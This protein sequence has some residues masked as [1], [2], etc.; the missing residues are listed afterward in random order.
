M[1]YDALEHIDLQLEE[2]SVKESPTISIDNYFSKDDWGHVDMK[3]VEKFKFMARRLIQLFLG[4]EATILEVEN[5][6]SIKHGTKTNG[7][8]F[9][10]DCKG[11]VDFSFKSTYEFTKYAMNNWFKINILD[12]ELCS[13]HLNP[14]LWEV[15][16]SGMTRIATFIYNV[17]GQTKSYQFIYNYIQKHYIT[18]TYKNKSGLS[19]KAMEMV[20]FQSITQCK[21]KKIKGESITY[22][23]H[24][25]GQRSTSR[26]DP[27]KLVC[28]AL[29]VAPKRKELIFRDERLKDIEE[30][31]SNTLTK[32]D[33]LKVFEYTKYNGFRLEDSKEPI[34]YMG[35][36][37]NPEIDYGAYIVFIDLGS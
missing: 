8:I 25:N 35:F 17:S 32:E 37:Y 26:F 31:A 18:G 29:S 22:N 3:S 33:I 13:Q 1:T 20:V 16:L 12:N 2:V 24:Q 27:K 9:K 14:N 7:Y 5:K 4:S 34:Y 19:R 23:F 6:A 21:S 10:Y 30:Y 36:V 11:N 28:V 15:G